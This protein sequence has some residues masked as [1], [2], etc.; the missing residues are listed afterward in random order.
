MTYTRTQSAFPC[1]LSPGQPSTEWP[2]A[3]VRIR[4]GIGTKTFTKWDPVVRQCQVSAVPRTKV[5]L[6]SPAFQITS[7]AQTCRDLIPVSL[8]SHRTDPLTWIL[9][10]IFL[11]EAVMELQVLWV[12]AARPPWG[13]GDLLCPSQL[14][15][16]NTVAKRRELTV[17]LPCAGAAQ[18]WT[19]S[20]FWL[21]CRYFRVLPVTAGHLI[22]TSAL[23]IPGP[24]PTGIKSE[25]QPNV[26]TTQ[27]FCLSHRR[28]SKLCPE[29]LDTQSISAS[30]KILDNLE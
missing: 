24:F 23:T 17:M 1:P 16:Q 7:H 3:L 13:P 12:P 9:E 15:P 28:I 11:P 25:I 27:N 2:R 22:P 19:G 20:Y 30:Q 8:N 4:E 29:P 6:H 5:P 21:S 14:Q 18:E 26:V 10:N